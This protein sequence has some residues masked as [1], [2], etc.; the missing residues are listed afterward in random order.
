MVK[1]VQLVVQ[2]KLNVFILIIGCF[3][4]CLKKKFYKQL[5]KSFS[6]LI[7]SLIFL[8]LGPKFLQ[9]YLTVPVGILETIIPKAEE[10]GYRAIV[11]TCDHPTDRMRDYI[12]PLFDEASKTIDLELQKSM[13]MPNM[14]FPDILV[15]QEFSTGSVTWANVEWIKRLTKLP[16]ICKGILSPIDAELAIKYGANGIIVRS[17]FSHI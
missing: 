8:I 9:V 17:I 4:L 7:F 5:V 14:N 10:N 16:I 13:P 11:I 3:Q 12:L 15:K 6:F 2:L 1:L